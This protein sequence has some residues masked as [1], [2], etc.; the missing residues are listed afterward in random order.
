MFSLLLCET[1]KRVS[2]ADGSASRR[3][4]CDVRLL[5]WRAYRYRTKDGVLQNF[6]RKAICYLMHES[7]TI[8]RQARA[9][10]GG[11]TSFCGLLHHAW[12]TNLFS[13]I[14][15]FSAV[16]KQLLPDVSGGIKARKNGSWMRFW[17]TRWKNKRSA[18][19]KTQT[20]ASD[21]CRPGAPRSPARNPQIRGRRPATGRAA[22][23]DRFYGSH[24]ARRKREPAQ[25]SFELLKAT[26]L[27]T[28]A[29]AC[30]GTPLHPRTQRRCE[31][32]ATRASRRR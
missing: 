29:D 10:K 27:C 4:Q 2:A 28:Q 15:G 6:L 32:G 22:D 7:L 25:R 17:L 30:A 31:A 21:T 16:H 26:W 14:P 24:A 23:P 9:C 8:N 5:P 3:L 20:T 18:M 13:D 12:P 1:V 11:A 19:E